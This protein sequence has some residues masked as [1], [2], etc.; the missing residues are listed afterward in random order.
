MN[1]NDLVIHITDLNGKLV[2]AATTENKEKSATEMN[3]HLS[4]LTRGI[5]FIE[6]KT[7]LSNEVVKKERIV[8]L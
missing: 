2:F 7:V 8:K 6:V 3:L 4:E 1:R 5:Y